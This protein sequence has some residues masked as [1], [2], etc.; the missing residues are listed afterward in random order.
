M[1]NATATAAGDCMQLTTTA[2][3]AGGKA[4]LGR[5]HLMAKKNVNNQKNCVEIRR[6]FQIID[7]KID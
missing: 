5:P 7:T 4:G 6:Y 2:K 1:Q 3:N